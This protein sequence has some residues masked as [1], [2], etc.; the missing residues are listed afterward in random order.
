MSPEIVFFIVDVIMY[1]LG[2]Y[3]GRKY[4]INRYAKIM[5]EDTDNMIEHLKNIQKIKMLE[6]ESSQTEV[7]VEQ[8]NNSYFVYNKETHLFLGQGTSVDEAMKIVTDRYPNQV[9][10][11]EE[12]N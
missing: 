8:H 10:F 4:M 3:A 1:T 6:D 2:F 7:V 9:F 5:S 11:Y 12:T